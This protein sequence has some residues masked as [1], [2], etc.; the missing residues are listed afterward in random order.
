MIF[1][2]DGNDGPWSS[3][4]IRVG[5]PAQILKVFC[6]TTVPETW[7]VSTEGCTKNDPS[8]CPTLRGGTFNINASTTWKDEGLY[9]LG[10]EMNLPYHENYDNGDYGL[11]TLGLGYPGSGSLTLNQQVIA[12]IAT[13]DFYLGNL[14]LAPW[15]IN[16]TSF[17][18]SAPSFLSNLKNQSLIPSLSYGY[19]AGA[20]YRESV[21]L[22]WYR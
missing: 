7:V 4:V 2:R 9:A 11:D 20:Q 3:L 8:N 12:S 1:I 13:K 6:S 15:P 17:E 19:N 18:D 22:Q 14:G 21:D 10:V 5:N 16:F